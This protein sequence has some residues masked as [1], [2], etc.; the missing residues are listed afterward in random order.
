[1]RLAFGQKIRRSFRYKRRGHQA[2]LYQTLPGT[3]EY[4]HVMSPAYATDSDGG[5]LDVTDV[6]AL[7]LA[8]RRLTG[9]AAPMRVTEVYA[10]VRYVP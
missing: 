6:G 9:G 4:I 2:R 8:V 3:G 7:Q 10:E 1:M 5:L